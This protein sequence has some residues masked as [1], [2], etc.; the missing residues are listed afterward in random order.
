MDTKPWESKLLGKSCF[1]IYL[2]AEQNADA[3]D[4]AVRVLGDEAN[5]LIDPVFIACRLPAHLTA[6]R[7]SLECCGFHLIECYLEL[8]AD[9][10]NTSPLKDDSGFKTR[11]HEDHDIADLAEIAYKSFAESRFHSDP[12]ID[13]A[14]ANESRADWVRNACAGRADFVL[15]SENA[16]ELMGFVIGTRNGNALNLDLIAISSAYRRKG[17]GGQLTNA[18]FEEAKSRGASKAI[19]GTQAHNTASLRMYQKS[20]FILS[21]AS[22]SYHLHG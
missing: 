16:G 13:D 15:V 2:E 1:Q 4:H 6:H 20:G 5:D 3:F 21:N 7:R 19:V 10:E 18:F 17:I 9:L 8:E 11:F 14:A 22:F 12:L